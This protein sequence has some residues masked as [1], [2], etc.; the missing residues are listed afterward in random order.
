[1]MSAD[2]EAAAT[3]Q[4]QQQ[5]KSILT[6]TTHTTLSVEVVDIKQRL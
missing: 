6:Q 5:T 1:M 3:K 4:Q 2:E